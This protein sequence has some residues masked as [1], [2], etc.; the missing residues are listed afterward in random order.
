MPL[1]PI[2]GAM[3]LNAQ[4]PALN[5]QQPALNAQQPALNAQRLG[6]ILDGIQPAITEE[7][8]AYLFLQFNVLKKDQKEAAEL[9]A[10]G[11]IVGFLDGMG[12][13]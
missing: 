1:H 10:D 13:A 11:F 2:S 5:A 12:G 8:R 7:R 6:R 9:I 3:A 4:Q